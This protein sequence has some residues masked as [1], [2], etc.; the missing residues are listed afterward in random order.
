M[1]IAKQGGAEA[2]IAMRKWALGCNT[3]CVGNKVWKWKIA[4]GR[5]GFV[6]GR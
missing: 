5:Y 3:R 6:C 2:T 4:L 1:K